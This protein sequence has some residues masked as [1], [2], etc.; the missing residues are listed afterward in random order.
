M[1]HPEDEALASRPRRAS[2]G[3]AFRWLG[4]GDFFWSFTRFAGA[5]IACC[6]G[7]RH[8]G[9]FVDEGAYEVSSEGVSDCRAVGALVAGEPLELDEGVEAFFGDEDGDGT[10]AHFSAS[11]SDAGARG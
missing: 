3:R 1:V 9:E 11:S 7:P 4:R 6:D 5:L 8:G 2:G 10:E